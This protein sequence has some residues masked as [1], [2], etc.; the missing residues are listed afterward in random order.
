M[1][2]IDGLHN[3]PERFKRCCSSVAPPPTNN[4]N[5][6]NNVVSTGHHVEARLV[7]CP[8]SEYI[9]ALNSIGCNQM[10]DVPTRF[11]NNCTSSLLDHLYTNIT[12]E[13]YFGVCLYEVSGHLPTFFIIP[14]FKCCLMNKQRLIT[15]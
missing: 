5:N 3:V 7:L 1:G 6:N 11:A 14:K 13:T 2:L 4:N 12:K 8:A 15:F 9:V 10:V